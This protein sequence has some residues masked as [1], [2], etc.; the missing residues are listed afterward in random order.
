MCDVSSDLSN[1]INT[2]GHQQVFISQPGNPRHRPT[3][4]SAHVKPN[5]RQITSNGICPTDVPGTVT[6]YWF[7]SMRC[8]LNMSCSW[9]WYALDYLRIS[10]LWPSSNQLRYWPARLPRQ[11]RKAGGKK[12][13]HIAD[14]VNCLNQG[15]GDSQWGGRTGS[16]SVSRLVGA[17]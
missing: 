2:H 17:G 7:P 9:Q 15:P 8:I 3:K 12:R 1:D 5:N 11:A 6:S 13:R 16:H 10:P 14:S 4:G